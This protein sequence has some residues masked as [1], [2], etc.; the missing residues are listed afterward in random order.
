MSES[1][2]VVCSACHGINRLPIARL[3]DD[4]RCGRC[5]EA[6]FPGHAIAAD[7]AEFERQLRHSGLPLLV[8]FWAPWCAP[9]RSMAP[10]FEAAATQL[11]RQFRLLKVDTE[12]EQALA[13]RFAIRS[14]PTLIVFRAG[15]EAARTSG[16]L[17]T[18]RLVK[19]AHD[20]V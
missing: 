12:N 19:W 7:S 18:V 4:A 15:K 16:A 3:N 13:A 20:A 8:D 6:L 2:Q 14:I 9:C 17:D 5:R 11:A 10:A 1:I